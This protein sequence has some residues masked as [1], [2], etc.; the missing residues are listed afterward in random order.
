MGISNHIRRFCLL[1]HRWNRIRRHSHLLGVMSR[2]R[3]P[4]ELRRWVGF[5]TAIMTHTGASWQLRNPTTGRA[6]TL[7]NPTPDGIMGH[8]GSADKFAIGFP[9]SM[10]TQLGETPRPIIGLDVHE[11]KPL[12][13]QARK[14]AAT[15]IRIGEVMR[16]RIR[17]Q[18][19]TIQTGPWI[20]SYRTA[21]GIK[22]TQTGF[23]SPGLWNVH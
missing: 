1:E 17:L 8:Q 14:L 6:T 21:P 3:D 19:P 11:G 12:K 16:T 4:R 7:T 23:T 15:G 9:Q 22:G 18:S 20:L 2:E 5:N 10:L 13:K